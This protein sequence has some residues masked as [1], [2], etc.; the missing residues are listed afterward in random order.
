LK[1]VILLVAL[2]LFAFSARFLVELQ[3]EVSKL[4]PHE[5]VCLTKKSSYDAIVHVADLPDIDKLTDRKGRH[6]DLKYAFRFWG[7]DTFVLSRPQWKCGIVIDP[8]SLRILINNDRFDLAFVKPENPNSI[9]PY[10][11][12]LFFVMLLITLFVAFLIFNQWLS[13]N[14][15]GKWNTNGIINVYIVDD[16]EKLRRDLKNKMG[17]S[18]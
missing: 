1:K 8:A 4:T 9:L 16:Y 5:T 3:P 7:E 18:P 17:L 10:V 2:F 11:A 6:L 13:N 14:Y 15:S 12:K